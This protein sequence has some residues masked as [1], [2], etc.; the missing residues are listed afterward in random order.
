MKKDES[1][2]YVDSLC[3]LSIYL[4]VLARHFPSRLAGVSADILTDMADQ[5]KDQKYTSLSANH[6]LM[7]I[8]S[9]L[10]RA[11][12][13]EAGSVALSEI[14]EGGSPSPVQA[15]G[16]RILEATYSPKAKT[17]EI[18]NRAGMSLFWQVT[19][20]GFDLEPPKTETKE[21][22]EVYREFCDAQGNKIASAR[23]GDELLVRLNVRT[24]GKKPVTDVALVDMLPAGLECDINSIRLPGGKTNWDPSYV[25]IREDRVVFFGTLRPELKT[26]EY[27][28][29]AV[30]AGA[31]TVPPL[32]AEAMYDKRT[33]AFRPQEPLTIKTK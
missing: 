12:A 9:Y 6:A 33:W 28:A 11:P 31:F 17:V 10:S 7:A 26:F 13:I 19:T 20:A 23:I 14:R 24:T 15:S 21:G 18:D 8:E 5:L 16:D 1:F 29:R 27:R 30:N 4:D 22:I 25:D 2:K 3:Y 32:F